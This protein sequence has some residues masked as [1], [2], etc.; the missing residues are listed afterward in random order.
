[1]ETG[2]GDQAGNHV[3]LYQPGSRWTHTIPHTDSNHKPE[4][5]R[6]NVALSQIHTF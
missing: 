5:I 1:M 4:L 2:A 3:D 6:M